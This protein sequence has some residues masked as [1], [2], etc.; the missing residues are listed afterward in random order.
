[1]N[2][3]LDPVILKQARKARGDTRPVIVGG[4]PNID[5]RRSF[6]EERRTEYLDYMSRGVAW[7]Q[8]AELVGIH[9]SQVDQYRAMEP[10]FAEQERR[11]TQISVERLQGTAYRSA[12]EFGSQPALEWVSKQLYPEKFIPDAARAKLAV[13][14]DGTVIHELT[15]SESL[16]HIAA[17]Q[18]KLEERKALLSGSFEDAEIVE[19]ED[20]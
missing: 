9:W 6:N 13:T 20:A 16:Q 1:M 3:G 2:T 15:A 12:E 11:A 4:I 19:P 17:L 18:A 5:R 7:P 8:A 14:I 10:S